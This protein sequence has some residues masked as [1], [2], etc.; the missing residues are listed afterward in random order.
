MTVVTQIKIK[1]GHEPAWDAAIAPP[2]NSRMG[3]LSILRPS[4]GGP[5]SPNGVPSQSRQI[6]QRSPG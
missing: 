3:W 6:T 4:Y 2:A 1:E 5:A